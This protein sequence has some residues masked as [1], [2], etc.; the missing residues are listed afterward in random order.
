M[1][2]TKEVT[3]GVEDVEKLRHAM[4]ELDNAAISISVYM[5][6][7]KIVKPEDITLLKTV[8]VRC[9]RGEARIKEA[10][11]PKDIKLSHPEVNDVPGTH[12]D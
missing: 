11:K 6:S 9:L 7:M 8:R 4:G 3:I 5:K 2:K 10:L 12:N 1:N